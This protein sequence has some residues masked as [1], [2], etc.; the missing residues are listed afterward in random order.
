VSEFHCMRAV[1]DV[2]FAWVRKIQ[3]CSYPSVRHLLC[4]VHVSDF[5]NQYLKIRSNLRRQRRKARAPSASRLCCHWHLSYPLWAL[6]DGSNGV[7]KS[8]KHS[9]EPSMDVTTS[10]WWYTYLLRKCWYLVAAISHVNG[11]SFMLERWHLV[12][13]QVFVFLLS[14]ASAGI[15]PSLAVVSKRLHQ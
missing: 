2:P 9:T 11:T 10:E 12:A 13:A 5:L 14:S 4:H 3:M 6:V 8:I 7:Y 15:W 1:R